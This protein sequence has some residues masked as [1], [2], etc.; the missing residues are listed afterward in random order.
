[1]KMLN[2]TAIMRLF[3]ILILAVYTAPA[4]PEQNSKARRRMSPGMKISMTGYPNS[5]DDDFMGCKEEM[6]DRVTKQLLDKELNSNENFKTDWNAA[7]KRLGLENTALTR[8]NLRSIALQAYTRNNIYSDLN[9]KM[10]E[11][12]GS[13]TNTFGLISLHFLMTDGIQTRNAKQ[14]PQGMCQTTYRRTKATIDLTDTLV[15]FGGFASS[16][17]KATLEHFGKETCFIITTCYGADISDVSVLPPEAEVLIPPYELFIQDPDIKD[18]DIP[19]EFKRDC[20]R[21][22]KLISVG[23]I[24]I[25]KCQLVNKVNAG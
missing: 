18:S 10:R 16:S 12:R 24:S 3:I 13:Y 7:K 11:G 17:L 22:Y 20:R 6:Y 4:T 9:N 23:Q 1:M 8:E 15:R 5:I 21:V 19:E 14:R 2:S 25:M